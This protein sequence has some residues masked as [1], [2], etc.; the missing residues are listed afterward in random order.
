MLPSLPLPL[1]LTLCYLSTSNSP[2]QKYWVFLFKAITLALYTAE[3]FM[4]IYS[5]LF[6]LVILLQLWKVIILS[7]TVVSYSLFCLD[8]NQREGTYLLCQ[9]EVC[10]F[11]VCFP[12]G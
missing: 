4:C 2:P 11:V 1:P 9:E 12:Q 3:H 10:L 8:Y 7:K 6:T 5:P